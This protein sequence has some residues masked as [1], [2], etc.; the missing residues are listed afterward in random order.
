MSHYYK[1]SGKVSPLAFIN[2]AWIV[3]IAMPLL[4]VA[5]AYLDWYSPLIYISGFITL[6]FGVAIMLVLADPVFKYG[7]VRNRVIAA[8]FGIL[9][10]LVALYVSWVVWIDLVLNAGQFYGATL[11]DVPMFGVTG[12]NLQWQQVVY[13]L[14]HPAEVW[15]IVVQINAVGVW[16][17]GHRTVHGIG[18]WLIWV[19]EMCLILGTSGYLGYEYSRKPFSERTQRWLTEK[20]LSNGAPILDILSFKSALERGDMRAF[21][22]IVSQPDEKAPHVSFTLYELDHSAEIYLLV[23][24]RPRH[25]IDSSKLDANTIVDYLEITEAQKRALMDR[26]ATTPT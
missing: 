13:L 14:L 17:I 9:A 24:D 10:G 20:S 2:F 11:H 7:N 12:S 18:L 3:I 16:G 4:G 25:K 6:F 26:L 19:S 23:M 8:L 1:P 21:D 5:Y 15:H 22:V